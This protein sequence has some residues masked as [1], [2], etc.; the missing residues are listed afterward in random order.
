MNKE[1]GC[2]KQKGFTLIELLGVL[3]ILGLLAGIAVPTIAS[4][5]RSSRQKA[6]DDQIGLII[7]STK[8]WVADHI[9]SLSE[10]DTTI[11]TFQELKSGGYMEQDIKNPKT[12]KKFSDT[13]Y[14]EIK[15]VLNGYQYE[16]FTQDE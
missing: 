15:P 7:A 14:V 10:E 1:D 12:Q 8:N 11:V 9:S 16:V 5:V 3:V 13:S 2:M 6:Y 4:V